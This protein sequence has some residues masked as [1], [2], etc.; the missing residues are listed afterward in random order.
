MLYF[1]LF[2]QYELFL[3]FGLKTNPNE[4]PNPVVNVRMSP[5]HAKVMT[6]FLRK[7]LKLYEKDIGEI[8]LL[9]ELV[10]DLGIEKEI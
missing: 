10:K 9:P 8:K 2:S 5:E 6:A 7:H 1:V 4:E 3:Q